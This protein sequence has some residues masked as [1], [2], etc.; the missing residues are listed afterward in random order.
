MDIENNIAGS[1]AIAKGNRA[2]GINID[3]LTIIMLNL[4]TP[5]INSLFPSQKLMGFSLLFTGIILI[6]TRKHKRTLKM[7][8]ILFIFFLVY[9]LN[10]VYFHITVLG[11]WFRMMLL[12]IPCFMYGAIILGDYN[13]SQILSALQRLGLP[14]IIIIGF[15]VTV[16]YIPTFYREFK[17]IRNS[18][19]IRGVEC[20]I[21]HPFRT[22]EY[23]IVPQLF[24]CVSISSELTA[25]GISKGINFPGK[26]TGY[27]VQGFRLQDYLILLIFA[28]G[29][30]LIIGGV[31]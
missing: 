29:M 24:R 3:P 6:M 12:F 30:A 18:M 14:K 10:G 20:T 2:K 9:Y 5:V 17:I 28:I 11:A 26:R 25:A 16:R 19:K 22:F 1:F 21:R 27:F 23:V 7:G 13:A 8:I 4:L 15:T 31:I